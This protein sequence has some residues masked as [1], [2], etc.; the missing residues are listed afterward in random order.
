MWKR[1]FGAPAVVLAAWS[2]ASCNTTTTKTT[3]PLPEKE[4]VVDAN[5]K[6]LYMAASAA[7]PQSAAQQRVILKMAQRAANGK[8]LLLAMR[9]AIGVFPANADSEEARVHAI[10]TAKMIELGTLDQM[11]EYATRYPVDPQSARPFV[12]R[13]FQL[14]DANTNPREWY[15][16]RVIARR[17][18]LNDLE[19][20]ALARGNQLAGR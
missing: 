18:K 9:A 14:A 16:I 2:M 11:L 19:G 1:F 4:Q 17:F 7:P 20:Q 5:L 13:M 10:V 6:D 3:A 12:E 8:E 15:R